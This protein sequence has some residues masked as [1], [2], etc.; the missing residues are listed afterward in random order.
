MNPEMP[1]ASAGGKYA[2]CPLP[3]THRRL[4]EAHLLWHQALDTYHDSSAFLANLNSTIEALRNVTFV[5]Q[6]E[7][8]VPDFDGPLR[9]QMGRLPPP[10][11]WRHARKVGHPN[12]KTTCATMT[13]APAKLRELG[14]RGSKHSDANM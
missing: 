2:R 11:E 6:K 13:S 5:L 12:A 14:F 8:T 1:G 9:D 7:R 4:G 3:K 10:L